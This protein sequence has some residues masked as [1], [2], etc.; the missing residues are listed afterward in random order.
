MA[1][2]Y[3]KK[4]YEMNGDLIWCSVYGYTM[5]TRKQMEAKGWHISGTYYECLTFWKEKEDWIS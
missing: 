2:V 1:R 4:V 3:K 5:D